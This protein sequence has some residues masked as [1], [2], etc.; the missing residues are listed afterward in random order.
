MG[1]KHVLMLTDDAGGSYY[2]HSVAEGSYGLTDLRSEA[3]GYPT[4]DA[5]IEAR[6]R[7]VA[8]GVQRADRLR[9]EIVLAD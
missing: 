6:A 4:R 2:A 7:L 1:T 3:T 5:A 8:R 9:P